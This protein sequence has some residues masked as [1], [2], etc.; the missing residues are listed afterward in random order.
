MNG[1]EF[2]DVLTVVSFMLQ[3]QNQSRIIDLG[4]VQDAVNRAVEEVHRHL[5]S[6]DNKIDH[7]IEVIDNEADR[8]VV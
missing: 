6:Q 1:L 2:L 5:E 7:I 8:K 3:V 4:D